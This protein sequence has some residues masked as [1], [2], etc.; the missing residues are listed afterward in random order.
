MRSYVDGAEDFVYLVGEVLIGYGSVIA[1]E[2][3]KT[4]VARSSSSQ[5]GSVSLKETTQAPPSTRE[6]LTE[7]ETN[8]VPSNLSDE[9]AQERRQPQPDV[10][11]VDQKEPNCSTTHSPAPRPTPSKRADAQSG[12]FWQTKQQKGPS[13]EEIQLREHIQTMKVDLKEDTTVLEWDEVYGLEHIK[14]ALEE[15]ATFFLH[16]PHLT[17]KLRHRSTTGILLFGPQGTGKT[18]LVKSFAVKFNLSLYDVRA[19][20]IMSKYVGE[21]EKFIKA[22]FAEVR[23]NTPAILMLDE[24][25]GLLCNPNADSTQSHHYRLLQTELKNQWSDLVYSRDEIIVVGATNKPHDIDMDGFGRRLSLKL[26]VELP[27]ESA[28]QAI[29]KAAMQMVTHSIDDDEFMALGHLCHD[30]G[31]SGYDVD[32]LV[33][34]QLRKAIR[35]ITLAQAF[36]QMTWGEETI[37]VPCEL[38]DPDAQI[39]HW[40]RLTGDY[41][42]ISY[43]P[44]S[45][46]EIK[47]AIQHARATVDPYMVQKHVEFASQYATNLD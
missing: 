43:V 47:V 23:S 4:A 24:C 41:E 16:F 30:R 18:L 32:C 20:A 29:I 19:S 21:S 9:T 33:E 44:F 8:A 31:L 40:T 42:T 10:M 12:S 35:K 38:T 13:E 39:G 7:V 45:F 22:L 46:K 14:I 34:A 2:L 17:R 27:N 37:V 36:R 3:I 1:A 6:G 11:D 28:S 25:D 26:H 5:V 15:F